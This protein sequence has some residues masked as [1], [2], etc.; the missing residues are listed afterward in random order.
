MAIRVCYWEVL[1]ND[2]ALDAL[3]K[4]ADVFVD[5]IVFCTEHRAM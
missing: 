1:I 2:L 5:I 3:D 4:A